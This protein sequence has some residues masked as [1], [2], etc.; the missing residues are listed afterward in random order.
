VT[1]Q[2]FSDDWCGIRCVVHC[3]SLTD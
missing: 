2:I 1:R 3:D